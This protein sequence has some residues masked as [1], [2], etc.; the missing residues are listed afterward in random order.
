V[1]TGSIISGGVEGA[2]AGAFGYVDTGI[3]MD[4]RGNPK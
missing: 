4:L 1:T 2:F 3:V